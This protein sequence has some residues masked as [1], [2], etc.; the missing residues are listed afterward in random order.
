MIACTSYGTHVPLTLTYFRPPS[1]CVITV[2]CKRTD[3]V[4]FQDFPTL[5][6][7][8]PSLSL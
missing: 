6:S 8:N 3:A 1:A 7:A 5:V 2:S 4:L